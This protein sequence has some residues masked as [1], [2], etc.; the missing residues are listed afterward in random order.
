MPARRWVELHHLLVELHGAGFFASLLGC[1]AEETAPARL[2]RTL[3]GGLELQWFGTDRRPRPFSS[4]SKSK[5]N[6]R[7][8][9][10]PSP[11]VPEGQPRSGSHQARLKQRIRHAATAFM[12]TIEW[13]INA[14]DVFLAQ[15]AQDSQ[16]PRSGMCSSAAGN[17]AG[18]LQ[19][20]NCGTDLQDAQHVL[21]AIAG[22]SSMPRGS[23]ANSWSGTQA[24]NSASRSTLV[25]N[26][27]IWNSY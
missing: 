15:R 25:L 2:L 7:R 21:A 27:C 17:D 9:G 23:P 26:S 10:Q 5:S 14:R 6:W 13:R 8:M 3:G 12:A 4:R 16:L 20:C 11:V 19:P 24:L 18:A 1:T 22:H